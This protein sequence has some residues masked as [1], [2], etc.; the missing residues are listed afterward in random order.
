MERD[1][2][3]LI[4]PQSTVWPSIAYANGQLDSQYSMQ[5]AIATPGNVHP[6]AIPVLHS[7]LTYCVL[8]PTQ[9]PIRA[10]WEIS[11]LL[12]VGYGVKA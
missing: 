12:T 7:L 1:C 8:R 2:H 9:P 10:R 11:S 6:C 5:C 4:V 3:E